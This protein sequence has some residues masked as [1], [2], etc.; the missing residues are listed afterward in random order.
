MGGVVQEHRREERLR[1][2]KAV[3]IASGVMLEK[4]DQMAQAN[5]PGAVAYRWYAGLLISLA[6]ELRY[7]AEQLGEQRG[8]E[9]EEGE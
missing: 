9:E 3:T 4:A 5:D 8:L 1:K 7:E 2:M 6:N